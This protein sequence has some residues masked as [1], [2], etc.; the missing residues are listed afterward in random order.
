MD[1]IIFGTVRVMSYR[2]SGS[3]TI[4]KAS[5]TVSVLETSSGNILMSAQREK[6]GLGNNNEGAASSAFKAMGKLL[7]T[8]IRNN[9]K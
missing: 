6:S 4:A 1:R 5:G 7:G 8:Q 2:K 9:L 3:K